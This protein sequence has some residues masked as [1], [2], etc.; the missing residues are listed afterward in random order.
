VEA[1]FSPWLERFGQTPR[2]TEIQTRL[3]LLSYERNPQ[4]SLA[5]LRDHLGLRFN[6]ERVI[7]GAIPQLPTALDPSAIARAALR[8]HS[9][10]AWKNLDNIEDSALDW[11]AA[12]NLDWERRRNLLQRLT[13]PD[14]ANLAR[15]VNDDLRSPRAA[16]FGSYP[17]HHQMTLAQLD[18]LVKL[19][20]AL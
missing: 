20:P 3:A 7:P 5:Y 8:A 10:N 16:P 17:I 14:V 4:K 13:R 11:L 1:L 2:V 6:H 19:Q 9:L 15:L 18:E 12:E